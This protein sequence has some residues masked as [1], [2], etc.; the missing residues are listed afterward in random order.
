MVSVRISR[1]LL[2][3][4]GVEAHPGCVT[5]EAFGVCSDLVF[6]GATYFLDLPVANLRLLPVS[7]P[8]SLNSLLF[9]S[10]FLARSMRI[11]CC[12]TSSSLLRLPTVEATFLISLALLTII[13]ASL[14][15]LSSHR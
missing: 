14:T 10:A 13:Y 2:G 6:S 11:S 3:S 9:N 15:Q 7:L 5:R 12:N 1:L 4:A 8:F